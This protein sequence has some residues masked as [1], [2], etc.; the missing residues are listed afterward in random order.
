MVVLAGRADVGL[1]PLGRRP[2]NYFVGS[3]GVWVHNCWAGEHHLIPKYMRGGAD[4]ART[5]LTHAQHVELHSLI[6][7]ASAARGIP[8]RADSAAKVDAWLRADPVN[9]PHELREAL[10][11]AYGAFDIRNG[12]NLLGDVMAEVRKRGF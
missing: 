3:D 7:H 2:P 9:R 8:K 10:V 5:P 12:T 4:W 11:E 1:Q 6:D